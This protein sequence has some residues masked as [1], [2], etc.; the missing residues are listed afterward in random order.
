M[1]ILPINKKQKTIDVPRNFFIYGATMSG[2]S[3]LAQQFPNPLFLNT[4]GNALSNAC[5]SIQL[6]NNDESNVLEDID[7]IVTELRHNNNKTGYG[8]ETIIIDV[9]DDVIQ[10]FEQAICKMNHVS[11]LSEIG[12]GKGFATFRS[13]INN[14]VNDLKSLNMNIVYI[15]RV[16]YI[17]EQNSDLVRE[18]PSL[19]TKFYNTINGNCD[20]VIK[21]QKIGKNYMKVVTDIRKKYYLEDMN[22]KKIA[23]ILHEIPGALYR[24]EK[25]KAIAT[26]EITTNK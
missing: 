5:P 16:D 19:A 22:N 14:F 10:L 12:Y 24:K 3:Y 4:D 23:K 17:Q 18:V 9:I 21:T 1:S 6:R 20:L 25:P 11:S 26:K 7:E 8:Y 2:K 13:V 15:S